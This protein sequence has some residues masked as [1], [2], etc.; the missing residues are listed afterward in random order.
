MNIVQTTLNV[1]TV[2][3]VVMAIGGNGLTTIAT[4]EERKEETAEELRIGDV[5]RWACAGEG[6]VAIESEK[7]EVKYTTQQPM[8]PR[9][10]YEQAYEALSICKRSDRDGEMYIVC[11]T[12][13]FSG[14]AVR[15]A[16]RVAV[17]QAIER[18]RSKD[19]SRR[20]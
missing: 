19:G 10:E 18:C 5:V 9:R 14:K 8:T 6:D 16:Q 1:V 12:A 17:Q 7:Y 4:A 3:Q 11:R 15:T 20:D 13:T 2:A